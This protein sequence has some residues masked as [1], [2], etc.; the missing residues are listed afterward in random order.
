MSK[1]SF[2]CP[3]C[4]KDLVVSSKVKIKKIDDLNGTKCSSCG[5]TIHKDDI[6]KQAGDYVS[7]LFR[8]AFKK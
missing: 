4:R 8:D 1:L 3:N 2:K 5:R 7:K 6:T